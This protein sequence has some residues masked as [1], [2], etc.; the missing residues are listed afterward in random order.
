[1][2]I[3]SKSRYKQIMHED[4]KEATGLNMSVVVIFQFMIGGLILLIGTKTDISILQFLGGLIFLFGHGLI[5]LFIGIR[6]TR[7]EKKEIRRLVREK[8]SSSNGRINNEEIK[9][10]M[11]EIQTE[12]C[13]IKKSNMDIMNVRK[14]VIL[15][16]KN[17]LEEEKEKTL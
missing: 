17:Y 4:F 13:F 2:K 15:E 16:L 10:L 7:K 5:V 12:M 11:Y 8:L 14:Q 9:R 3:V 6:V 1:M